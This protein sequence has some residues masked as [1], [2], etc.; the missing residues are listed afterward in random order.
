[1]NS[2]WVGWMCTGTNWPG[3]LLVSNAKVDS[4]T[5]LGVQRVVRIARREQHPQRGTRDNHL[6][7]Q[8]AA[9]DVA[10][11]HDVGEQQVE[12]LALG[13]DGE[14]FRRVGRGDDGVAE[15]LELDR[16]VLAHVA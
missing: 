2:S 11:H 5:A 15:A 14:R 1:M 12:R 6:L 7:G 9:V 4:V 10:G 3:S 16:D 13:G 8:L